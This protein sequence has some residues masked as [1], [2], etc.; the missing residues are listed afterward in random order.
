MQ[1]EIFRISCNNFC[2]ICKNYNIFINSA[3]IC[4]LAEL[5]EIPLT[6]LIIL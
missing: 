4:R 2:L 3:L 5:M 1:I 6:L